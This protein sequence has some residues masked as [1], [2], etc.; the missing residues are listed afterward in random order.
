MSKLS[1]ENKSRV[2][3]VIAEHLEVDVENVLDAMHFKDDLGGDS[4][5]VVEII[6]ELEREFDIQIPDSSI[7]TPQFVKDFH[8]IIENIIN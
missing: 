2:R 1:E 3:K 8:E 4:L 7:E 6:M 5:D